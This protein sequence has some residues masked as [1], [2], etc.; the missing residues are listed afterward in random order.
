MHHRYCIVSF[1]QFVV[2]PSVVSKTTAQEWH[3]QV[4]AGL[5]KI[6]ARGSVIVAVEGINGTI[7]YPI[8]HN[9]ED[10][11][12]DSISEKQRRMVPEVLTERFPHLR[13]RISYSDSNV[14]SRLKVKLKNE[15]V[16]MTGK[17]EEK[18]IVRPSRVGTY[19]KPSDWDTTILQDPDCL[20][21]DT[22]NEYEIQLGAFDRAVNPHTREFAEF[23]HWL[24]QQLSSRLSSSSDS[25]TTLKMPKKIAMYCTGGIRCE[26]ATAFCLQ[27]LQQFGA[28][29][30]TDTTS[31]MIPQVYH[32][33]G[34]ILAYLDEI[35]PERSRFRGECYVFDQRIAVSY[36]LRPTERYTV[37][38]AC[39]HPLE[40]HE[41]IESPWYIPGIACPYCYKDRIHLR[42][43][44][45]NRQRQI[46]LANMRGIPHIHDPKEHT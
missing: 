39:R 5:R 42:N 43:R 35:P 19:V 10:K 8:P 7:C 46:E 37:C 22:R 23:P 27:L 9:D 16:T 40:N 21:I 41:I 18:A 34:G 32:L 28:Q 30:S 44:Y 3:Q 17:S 6:S 38:H 36:H 25:S 31:I 12:D 13:T 2:E 15:I 26:K 4:E 20:V 33:E 29:Q 45:E 14:F 11:H 1:Y 24:H